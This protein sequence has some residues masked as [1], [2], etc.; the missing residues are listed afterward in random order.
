MDMCTIMGAPDIF[1]LD[2][3]G[4]GLPL[5]EMEFLKQVL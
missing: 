5:S 2:S 4:T 1:G 3:S